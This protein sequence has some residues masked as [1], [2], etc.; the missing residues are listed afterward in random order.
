[1]KFVTFG[2][3]GGVSP[4]AGLIDGQGQ[5]IDLARGMEVAAR[6]G[7][8]DGKQPLPR[9]PTLCEFI[10][11]GE[12]AVAVAR[13]L[14]DHGADRAMAPALVPWEHTVLLA[15][16]PWP[17]KG[18]YCVGLN[19]TDH[20]A[21][22]HKA[23]GTTGGVPEYPQFFVKAS[24]AVIGPDAEIRLDPRA[25]E[26]L[27]YEVEL[28]VVIGTAGRDIPAERAYDHVFGYTILNDV[29]AR[30]LQ[31]RHQA[32]K[33]K[34]LDTFCPMGPWILH[35]SKVPDPQN[36]DISLSVN[37]QRRQ[38][39]NTAAMIFDIRRL[40]ED[41]SRGMTLEPGD[42]IATGTPA[43]VGYAMEPPALLKAGDIVECRVERL[44]T[45]TNRVVAA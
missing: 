41:L 16:I 4:R 29:T 7:W 11:C 31:R 25:T 40:I 10:A 26:K 13:A 32:F 28:A 14:A 24:S 30:D 19:Y 6:H 34:S 33:G 17:R 15:P 9:A 8:L 37:G 2:R 22:G 38:H 20:V 18:V 36:L 23:R 39:S 27:D 1:M 44:G 35:K 21:E 45:L 43:G 5:L 12:A 3:T 42:I